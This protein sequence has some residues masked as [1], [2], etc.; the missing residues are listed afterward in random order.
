MTPR[1]FGRS[2]SI[3]AN[4]HVPESG[5]EG[6]LVANADFMG[7]YAL[8]VN[9][10]GRLCH[11]Y[12]LLGVDTYRQVSD[13]PIPAGDVTLK[14]LF[15]ADEAKPG[16]PGTVTLWAGDR[17][18]GEGRLE[19]TVPVAFTSYAGMDIGRDNG[20]VVDLEYEDRAPFA[21]TGTI[22]DV[23][24]DLAPAGLEDETA[25]HHHAA[26]HAVAAGVAG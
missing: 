25:L 4:V 11:T 18:I 2:Y 9:E 10:E 14:M 6:V 22:R 12:S 17:Q 15:Q 24:F 8:W 26:V 13:E 5:A 20:G 7:G 16:T 1:I 21:F 3:E 23:I 19:H